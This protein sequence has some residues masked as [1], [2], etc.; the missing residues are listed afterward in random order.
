MLGDNVLRVRITNSDFDFSFNIWIYREVIGDENNQNL[1]VAYPNENGNL[2]WRAIERNA[3]V[4]PTLR[5]SP[6]ILKLLANA[7]NKMNIKPE[8][9]SKTMG[10]YEASQKHL[11]DMRRIVFKEY[12]DGK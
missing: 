2:E 3:E 6:E 9:E 5:V 8:E 12:K 4:A 7:L 11:E 1:R 10:L